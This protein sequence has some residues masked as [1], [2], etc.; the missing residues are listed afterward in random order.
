M[1]RQVQLAHKYVHPRLCCVHDQTHI[2][3]QININIETQ[4]QQ[5]ETWCYHQLIVTGNDD[6]FEQISILTET[7]NFKSF[8]FKFMFLLY[9]IS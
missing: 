1:H 6:C 3:M 5:K 8:Y 4:H 2:N 9:N 7:A